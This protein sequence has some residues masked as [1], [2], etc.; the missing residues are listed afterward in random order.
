MCGGGGGAGS[1]QGVKKREREREEHEHTLI[2]TLDMIG[3][4]PGPDCI[5]LTAFCVILRRFR[6]GIHFYCFSY[7]TARPARSAS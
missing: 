3:F 4:L 7:N 2:K 5:F 6:Q 1:S